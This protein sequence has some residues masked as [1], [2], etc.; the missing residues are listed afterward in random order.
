MT[1]IRD[2]LHEAVSFPV[3]PGIPV[4][5]SDGKELGTI[6]EVAD[7]S[8][9]VDAPMRPDFWLARNTILS[10]TPERVT[11]SFES[12]AIDNYRLTGPD[13][14]V[15]PVSEPEPTSDPLLNNAGHPILLDDEEQ[16]DQRERME[17]EL[18]EQRKH[19]PNA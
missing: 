14:V 5:T 17:R 9:K 6:K 19:L 7:Q 11:M 2:D 3:N 1:S 10:S 4:M 16:L 15:E 12:D 8:F 18:A 13:A